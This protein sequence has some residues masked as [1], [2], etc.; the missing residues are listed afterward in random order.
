MDIEVFKN[1][2]EIGQ[3]LGAGASVILGAGLVIVW[4]RYQKECEYSR[5]QDRATII[6]AQGLTSLLDKLQHLN[7]SNTSEILNSLAKLT[8]MV[9]DH[10][11][12]GRS[13]IEALMDVKMKLTILI[14]RVERMKPH[15]R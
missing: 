15:V 12:V 1:W 3:K 4:R 9:S 7:I 11:L 2:M 13:N 6:M 10:G 14:E 5:A 8:T